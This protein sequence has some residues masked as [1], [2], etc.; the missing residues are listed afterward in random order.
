MR[1]L[2]DVESRLVSLGLR[3]SASLFYSA[4]TRQR[5]DDADDLELRIENMATLH[6]ILRVQ[7]TPA[8][9]FQRFFEGGVGLGY[10]AP[11]ASQGERQGLAAV[12]FEAAFAS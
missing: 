5:R 1:S 10:S 7:T 3:S 12:M 8:K 4:A 9:L 11:L 6:G 2:T